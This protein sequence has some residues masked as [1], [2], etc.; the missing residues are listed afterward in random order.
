M[1]VL[2]IPRYGTPHAFNFV[3]SNGQYRTMCGKNFTKDMV[4]NTIAGDGV[5][6][7]MC[8]SCYD[9]IKD[10]YE[11]DLDCDPRMARN[12]W[13]LKLDNLRDFHYQDIL[14]PIISSYEMTDRIWRKLNKLKRTLLKIKK[15]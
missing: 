7:G 12:T 6:P 9:A 13:Q 1:L 2:L 3:L 5:F 14:G 15:K 11:D 10:M 4:C 8:Q